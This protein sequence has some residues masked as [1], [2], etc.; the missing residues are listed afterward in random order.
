MKHKQTDETQTECFCAKCRSN[1]LF[2]LWVTETVEF[3]IIYCISCCCLKWVIPC[4]MLHIFYYLLSILSCFYR[5][6][7]TL[8]YNWCCT[9]K[10]SWIVL[11]LTPAF[12][13]N[14]GKKIQKHAAN[15]TDIFFQGTQLTHKTD[16][17]FQWCWRI[18]NHC[19]MY[20]CMWLCSISANKPMFPN[21]WIPLKF[22]LCLCFVCVCVW[23]LWA[24]EILILNKLI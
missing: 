4:Y 7:F 13:Q 18:N 8:V 14:A 21:W 9:N 10:V 20:F 1:L 12:K 16:F 17:R 22:I 3:Y 6:F 23:A 11:N 5:F 24:I 2:L 15:C 19:I